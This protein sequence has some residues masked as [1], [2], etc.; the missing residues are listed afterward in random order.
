[1]SVRLNFAVG[2]CTFMEK[3]DS[4]LSEL[5]RRGH[6]VTRQWTTSEYTLDAV[7][8]P[9]IAILKTPSFHSPKKV[10]KHF[11]EIK[12][13]RMKVDAGR[14]LKSQRAGCQRCK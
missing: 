11:H 12:L 10:S 3:F 1:M 5:E 7:V 6:E 9:D 2:E 13:A 14:C 8:S 4:I